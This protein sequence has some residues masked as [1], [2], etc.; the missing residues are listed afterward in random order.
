MQGS[1]NQGVM[2][3]A[4]PEPIR[5][6]LSRTAMLV[7]DM[8]NAFVKPGGYL[9]VAGRDLSRTEQIVE[10][11]RK[12]LQAARGKGIKILYF[13]M[14]CSADQSDMGP[15]DSPGVRKSK[16]LNW[17][18]SRPELRDQLYVYGTWGAE[19]IPELAPQD[20]D[21]VLRKQK[22]DAFIGTNL[23]IILRT[24]KIKYLLFT[25]TATN[26]CVDSTLRHAFFLDYF[27]VL[28]ADAV[29]PLGPD[30]IQEAIIL[31]VQS[32]FGWVTRSESLLKVL[33]PIND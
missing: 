28:V 30:L 19:I 16:A 5:I 6:E 26:I 8:Q 29:S 23:D 25:G 33:H 15:V 21:I 12:I 31:N 2:V 27:P 14:G 11:C 20:G 7:V 9:D 17:I 1:E 13:Q 10:P 4:E 32:S 3:E 18:R 24:L 22:Y